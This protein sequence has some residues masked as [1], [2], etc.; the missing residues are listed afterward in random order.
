MTF[1][2]AEFKKHRQLR[3]TFHNWA[4]TCTDILAAYESGERDFAYANITPEPRDSF[5]NGIL[6]GADFKHADLR[7]I[8]FAGAWLEHAEFNGADLQEAD[9]ENAR[10]LLANFS[11]ADLRHAKLI[12]IQGNGSRFN[13]AKLR[14]ADFSRANLFRADFI[15][16]NLIATNFAQADV[17]RACFDDT[18]LIGRLMFTDAGLRPNFFGAIG[19]YSAFAP[20]MSSRTDRL[21]G[22]VDLNGD[23]YLQAGCFMGD[24]MK[25]RER[26]ERQPHNWRVRHKQRYLVAID[27]IEAQYRL[28]VAAG[29]WPNRG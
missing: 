8:S 1:D 17:R 9:F 14:W 16:A 20:G 24:A 13:E 25:L 7:G 29:V 5:A 11:G 23:L 4:P 6:N 3:R 18:E 28:D 10:L 26:I 27:F 15:E 21:Y 19:F 22:G 12:R 2:L